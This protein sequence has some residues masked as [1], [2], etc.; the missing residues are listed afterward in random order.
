MR[1]LLS[2]Q[3]TIA[4]T[5]YHLTAKCR[6]TVGEM[7]VFFVAYASVCRYTFSSDI[8]L[9]GSTMPPGDEEAQ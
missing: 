6:E 2:S 5:D 8:A 9:A 7:W 4:I 3:R 1:L